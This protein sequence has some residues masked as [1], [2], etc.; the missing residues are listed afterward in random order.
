MLVT[1]LV[2]VTQAVYVLLGAAAFAALL[3]GLVLGFML[4]NV[5]GGGE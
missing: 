1:A 4:T 5:G 2:S 3:L